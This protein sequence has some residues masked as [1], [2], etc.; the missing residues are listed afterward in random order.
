MQAKHDVQAEQNIQADQS[1]QADQTTQADQITQ[2]D[3]TTQADQ[4][5]QAMQDIAAMQADVVDKAS[6]LLDA[7]SKTCTEPASAMRHQHDQ[8]PARR[9]DRYQG[10]ER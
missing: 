4:N 5:T 6:S 1:T 7:V 9:P 10:T 8:S 2:V 3:Q